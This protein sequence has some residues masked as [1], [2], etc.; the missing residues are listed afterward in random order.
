M[1]QEAIAAYVAAGVAFVSLIVSVIYVWLSG[2]ASNLNKRMFKRQ[3]IIDLF[4]AWRGTNS[5]DPKNLVI[6]DVVNGVNA[7]DLTASLWNHD[8]IEKN[9]LYQSYWRPY[10][11]FYYSIRYSETLVPG[12]NKKLRELVTPEIEIAYDQMKNYNPVR[13]TKI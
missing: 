4:M 11:D 2:S 8:V 7:L 6:S 1:S 10:K 9:V 3:G 5:I 13:Q 12:L